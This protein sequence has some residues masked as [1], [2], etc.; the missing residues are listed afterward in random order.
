MISTV[1][2]STVSTVTTISIAGSLTLVA[3]L[4]FLLLLVQKEITT[5]VHDRIA[6]ALG[7]ALNVAIIPLFIAFVL[8]AIVRVLDVLK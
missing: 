8:I 2:L 5:S 4:T 1:T 3:V 6:H 7:R